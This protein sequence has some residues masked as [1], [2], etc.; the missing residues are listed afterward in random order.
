[1]EDLIWVLEKE[2]IDTIQD[3]SDK[4]CKTAVLGGEGATQVFEW[5]YVAAHALVLMIRG[6]VIFLMARVFGC[7]V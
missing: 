7:I 3:L 4:H 6:E 1:M 2:M 5:I